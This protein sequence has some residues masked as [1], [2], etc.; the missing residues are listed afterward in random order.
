MA[1]IRLLKQYA[2]SGISVYSMLKATKIEDERNLQRPFKLIDPKEV[3][4]IIYKWS[5]ERK[6]RL[7]TIQLRMH[8]PSHCIMHCVG[9]RAHRRHI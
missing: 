3:I 2:E 4:S 8:D 1:N 5:S 7:A 6:G 9:L